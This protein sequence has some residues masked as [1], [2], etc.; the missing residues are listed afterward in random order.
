MSANLAVYQRQNDPKV[1]RL[2][3]RARRATWIAPFAGVGGMVAGMV[4]QA[5]VGNLWP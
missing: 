3:L 2:R 4:G 5:L 1:E